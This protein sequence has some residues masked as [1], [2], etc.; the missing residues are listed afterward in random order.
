[1]LDCPVC[2]VKN[3]EDTHCPQC[4]TD[5]RPLLRLRELPETYCSEGQSLAEQGKLDEAIEK[6]STA[7]SLNSSTVAPYA[8]LGGVYVKKKM[9]NEALFHF[10]RALE[11]DPENE[12]VKKAAGDAERAMDEIRENRE[13]E[14]S[15]NSLLRKLLI[16]IPV[17][18]FLL[19]LVI[20]PIYQKYLKHAPEVDYPALSAHIKDGIVNNSELTGADVSVIY[21]D[22][23]L[24]VSGSVPT[25]THLNL[26]KAIAANADSHIAVNTENLKVVPAPV[27]P[28]VFSYTVKQN[29]TL[30]L[31]AYHFFNDS[32]MLDA[33]YD[34]NR[35]IID[36]KNIIYAGQVLKIPLENK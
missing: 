14:K 33:I 30:S 13:K 17:A 2:P 9:F 11:I 25:K 31:I 20:V 28:P 15:K 23:E 19:G 16:G 10:K 32:G 8:A 12:D 24:Y 5:L 36:D 34:A 3:I 26:V 7:I 22:N 6:L 18:A 27:E 1:M 21:R 4:K 29:D 35:D